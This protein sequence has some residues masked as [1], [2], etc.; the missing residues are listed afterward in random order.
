ME[1]SIDRSG[2][3]LEKQLHYVQA[4]QEIEKADLEQCRQ[5]A[6]NYVSLYLGTQVAVINM[7]KMESPQPLKASPWANKDEGPC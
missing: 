1:S 3:P 6:R 5:I 4:S 2:W 7:L